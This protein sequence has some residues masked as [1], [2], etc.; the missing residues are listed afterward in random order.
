[1]QDVV[2]VRNAAGRRCGGEVVAFVREAD[3]TGRLG[4]AR[5]GGRRR[6]RSRSPAEAVR[7]QVHREVAAT[8]RRV[9]AA[10]GLDRPRAALLASLGPPRRVRRGRGGRV[11]RG[12]VVLVAAGHALCAGSRPDRAPAALALQRH[13]ATTTTTTTTQRTADYR[14]RQRS[15]RSL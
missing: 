13:G 2:F 9:P 6:G 11:G 12:G 4:R 5:D 15:C 1:M 7:A 3:A 10:P 8:A 14:H